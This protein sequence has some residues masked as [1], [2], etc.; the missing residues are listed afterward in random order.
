MQTIFDT[1]PPKLIKT[2][3]NSVSKLCVE[4]VK[5]ASFGELTNQKFWPI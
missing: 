3:A 1:G 5:I 2:G 4:K